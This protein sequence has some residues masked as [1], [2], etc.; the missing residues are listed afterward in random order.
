MKLLKI[1]ERRRLYNR[2][3][4]YVDPQQGGYRGMGGREVTAVG[5]DC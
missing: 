5:N 4:F 3:T 1:Q 2:N